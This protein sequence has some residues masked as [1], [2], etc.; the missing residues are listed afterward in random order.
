MPVKLTSHGLDRSV[1]ELRLYKGFT[2]D[3]TITLEDRG[4]CIDPVGPSRFRNKRPGV[5]GAPQHHHLA[6]FSY[7]Y[8]VMP[9]SL[10]LCLALALWPAADDSKLGLEHLDKPGIFEFHGSQ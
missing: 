6:T 3:A 4:W 9:F 10:F 5:L 2:K 8:Y 7:W 1:A